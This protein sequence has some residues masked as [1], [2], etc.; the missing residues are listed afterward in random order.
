VSTDFPDLV[1]SVLPLVVESWAEKEPE[2]PFLLQIGG[3]S[4][5]YREAHELALTWSA[6]FRRFGVTAGDRVLAMRRPHVDGV[7]MWLGQGWLGAVETSINTDYRGAMLE[8]VLGNAEPRLLVIADEFLP[9]FAELGDA[10]DPDL[11]VVVPDTDHPTAS[12]PCRVIGRA[13]AFDGTAAEPPSYRPGPWDA[14]CVIYTSGTTGPSKGVIVPWA[15]IHATATGCFPTELLGDDEVFYSPFTMFHM[16]GKMPPAVVGTCG[17]QLVVRETVSLTAL[18][19]DIRQ[20]RSTMT[21]GSSVMTDLLMALPPSDSD[22]DLCL[23]WLMTGPATPAIKVFGERFDVQVGT[24]FNMTEISVALTSGWGMSNMASCGRLREGYPGYEVRLVDEHDRDVPTGE[25]GELI[26]R[27]SV[28]WTVNSGY[29]GY[30]EKTAEAW[31]N[32]WFHTGDAMRVDENGDY[33]FVDRIQD[34]IRR[35]GENI[36]S[37]EVE[38]AVVSHPDVAECAAVAVPDTASGQEVKVFVLRRPES[39]LGEREL[40]EWLVPR[41]PR[42]MV[43][44]YVELVTDF[45]RTEASMKVKKAELRQRP[46]TEATW[47]REAAGLVVPR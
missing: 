26:V 2:R 15:Q 13:E 47:D 16:S 1:G 9:R 37:F 10:L 11:V 23:R 31:R 27:T 12:L 34:A 22:K 25:V 21:I 20:T 8:Y 6:V 4:L 39:T 28:P 45:P 7:A 40:L 5:S 35:R 42:F 18:W 17:G 33:Y 38:A 24:A 41:M 43:P 32:G 36:S 29:L 3:P 19:D 30:P 46:L 14:A 44:R